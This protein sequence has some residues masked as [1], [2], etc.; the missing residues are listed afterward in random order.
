MRHDKACC[1]DD[2]GHEPSHIVRGLI[3]SASA[4]TGV[5]VSNVISTSLERAS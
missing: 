4:A 1:V 5:C 2:G 3:V